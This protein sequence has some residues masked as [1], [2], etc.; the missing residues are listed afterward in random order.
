MMT[1]YRF[2]LIVVS[3]HRKA[4][5]GHSSFDKKQRACRAVF[6]PARKK[7]GDAAVCR[8]KSIFLFL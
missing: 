4:L 2:L 5:K 7:R 1:L 8:Q 6:P 3:T